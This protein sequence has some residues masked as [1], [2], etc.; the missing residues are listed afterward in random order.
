[1][2]YRLQDIHREISHVLTKQ[3]SPTLK[4]RAKGYARVGKRN[5]YLR[6]WPR[7]GVE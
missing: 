5:H 6:K 3:L 1:V 2:V 7:Q 4:H